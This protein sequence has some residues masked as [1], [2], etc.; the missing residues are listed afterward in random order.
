MAREF[1]PL[2]AGVTND[3]T[4]S[5]G[6]FVFDPA[7]T[8]TEDFTVRPVMDAPANRVVTHSVFSLTLST[9]ILGSTTDDTVRAAVATLTKSADKLIVRGKGWGDGF[10]DVNLTAG[11]ARDVLW[12]PVPKVVGLRP[13]GAK[14]RAVVLRWT[15]EWAMPTC[16]DAKF[17]GVLSV[18]R[19]VAFDIDKYGL[20]RRTVSGFVQIAATRKSVTDPA[21]PDTADTDDNRRLL[22]PPLLSG[23][24]RTP[25]NFE[26]DES[27]CKLTLAG[28]Q[29]EQMGRNIPPPG[30]RTAKLSH[31]FSNTPRS[32]VQ[33]VGTLSGVY[34]LARGTDPS[35]AVAAFFD[36]AKRRVA[37][38]RAAPPTAVGGAK[39]ERVGVIF[40]NAD[41]EDPDTYA[42][43]QIVRCRL[44]YLVNGAGLE[45]LLS[46]SGIFRPMPDTWGAWSAALTGVLGPRGAAG[47]RFNADDEVIVSLCDRTQERTLS[48][49]TAEPGQRPVDS[50]TGSV[51][52]PDE[53]RSWLDYR[54]GLSS[55][56]DERCLMSA[57]L[58]A[59]PVKWEERSLAT[60]DAPDPFDRAVLPGTQSSEKNPQV[61]GRL[62]EPQKTGD[63]PRADTQGKPITY[64]YLVGEALRVF[65][66]IPQP[67]IDKIGGLTVT[68][69]CR[70][71]KGEGFVTSV[72]GS[73]GGWPTWYA[74]WNLRY[75]VTDLTARENTVPVPPPKRK[76]GGWGGGDWGGALPD[77]PGV[78]DLG[79]PFG[80]DPAL[81]TPTPPS[82]HSTDGL[83]LPPP[84][85]N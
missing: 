62:T 45:G 43:V 46:S 18:Q 26:V 23:F 52:P 29:D 2:G 63:E 69:A 19:K 4:C 67:Q 49:G 44:T 27:K 60:G 76:A 82:G 16:T 17:K 50:V 54:I 64:V 1:H 8:L 47:L 11:G 3:V 7:T 59:D 15:V 20:T 42:R 84:A 78:G 66:P 22:T 39:I 75:A 33:W 41:I 56:A 9:W 25:G 74:R 48:T 32:L 31:G 51:P 28:C 57:T 65:H 24:E 10:L 35:V 34:E 85:F 53:D 5:Y 72:V 58:P 55:E 14:R 81:F 13:A 38:I 12:G 61:W 36:E 83:P 71:D 79:G 80:L 40:L 6:D 73:L 37:A 30:C 68:P 21:L 77:P 70:L